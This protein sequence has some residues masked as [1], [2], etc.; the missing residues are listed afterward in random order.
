M[1]YQQ[2]PD[3]VVFHGNCQDGF[4]AAWVCYLAFGYSP[5][6]LPATHGDTPPDPSFFAGKDVLMV[7]FT[8]KHDYMVQIGTVANSVIILD[9]HKS[10]AEDLAK[11]PDFTVPDFP[12]RQTDPWESYRNAIDWAK[13]Q[14]HGVVS[15]FDMKRSGAMLA[16]NF[17]FPN[18]PAPLIV[19]IV[20][21]RDLW[22]F[23]LSNTKEI[24]AWLASFEFTMSNW[25]M[26]HQMIADAVE[27]AKLV[28]A[29][30]TVMRKLMKDLE[31]L[32]PL[33]AS[34]GTIDGHQVPIA[35]LP[36]T[37]ASEG[38]NLLAEKYKMMPFAATYWIA[39]DGSANFSLRSLKGTGADVQ[40]VAVK[41]GGG[42]HANA[43]GFKMPSQGKPVCVWP[44]EAAGRLS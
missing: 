31:E 41:F 6:Y 10:A 21:D 14:G 5:M 18:E 9:H 27:R 25:T 15:G 19:S 13:D 32:L 37:M 3:I 29:G 4:T 38:A 34:L 35:N 39:G 33:T 16:W 23:E 2:K 24:T 22:K 42:G 8:W 44:E 1:T 40:A 7:D 17:L 30:E 12:R 28:T 43:A 36:T 11:F 26:A 20:Q